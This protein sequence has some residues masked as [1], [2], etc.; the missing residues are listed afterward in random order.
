MFQA[1][2]ASTKDF[3]QNSRPG[4]ITPGHETLQSTRQYVMD[5]GM[6]ELL[7]ILCYSNYK[8]RHAFCYLK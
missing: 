8:L 3:S 7:K 2:Q 5:M 6:V 1:Q 4:A